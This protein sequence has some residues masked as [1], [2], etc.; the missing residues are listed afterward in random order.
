MTE[1]KKSESS[2]ERTEPSAP[3]DLINFKDTVEARHADANKMQQLE[4]RRTTAHTGSAG[5]SQDGSIEIDFG[6]CHPGL[7]HAGH[8]R[9]RM[10]RTAPKDGNGQK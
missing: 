3:K 5:E 9:R 2:T 8:E 4:S 6:S 7:R 10:Y 1:T